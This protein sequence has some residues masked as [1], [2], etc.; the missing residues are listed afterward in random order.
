M[1]LDRTQLRVQF[2]QWLPRAGLAVIS[3]ARAILIAVVPLNHDR[4]TM[5]H[6]ATS[7]HQITLYRKKQT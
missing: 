2:L 4:A 5:L 1:Y 7:I 6:Y 3:F